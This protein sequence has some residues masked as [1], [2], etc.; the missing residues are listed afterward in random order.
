MGS[1]AVSTQAFIHDYFAASILTKLSAME[2]LGPQIEEAGLLISKAIRGGKKWIL[3]GNGGSA[4]DA[5]HLAAELVG[6]LYKLERRGLP[7]LALTTD[8]SALTCVGNDYGFDEIFA[9]QVEALAQ[10][11]DVV[12]G[13]STSGNSPNVLKGLAMAKRLGC[14][15]LGLS[16]KEGGKLAKAVDLCLNVADE[17]TN[18]VQESHITI[19]HLLCFLVERELLRSGYLK[20]RR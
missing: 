10:K 20:A 6:R 5:Q 11:G 16:G 1:S 4:A 8:S 2:S 9:R 7:A 14:V 19:G 18:H 13:I 15:T 3:F 12:L 17:R